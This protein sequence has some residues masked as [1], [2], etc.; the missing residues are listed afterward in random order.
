MGL[1]AKTVTLGNWLSRRYC[2]YLVAEK[3][4]KKVPANSPNAE[5]FS[6]CFTA[7]VSIEFT[8]WPSLEI[9][10]VLAS[11]RRSDMKKPNN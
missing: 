8:M 2:V 3:G 9:M 6:D 5:R 7:R 11:D 4:V 1:E 10:A